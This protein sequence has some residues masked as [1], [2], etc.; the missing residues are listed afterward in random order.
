M[1]LLALRIAALVCCLSVVAA[2]ACAATAKPGQAAGDYLQACRGGAMPGHASVDL[3]AAQQQVIYLD[4]W[5]SWCTTCAKSFPFL[6][7]LVQAYQGK[8]LLVVGINVDEKIDDASEFL[9]RHP[10]SFPLVSDPAGS[11]PQAFNI[12][13]MPA[14]YLIDRHGIIRKLY[15]GFRR[16]D[17]AERRQEI[18]KLLAEDVSLRARPE[19]LA[20]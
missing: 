15:I 2:A 11:C 20:P 9:R 19:A 14:T 3:A 10:V 8:G 17:E 5:A 7:S 16:E 12:P 6:D 1:K 13:G 4:F 18:E